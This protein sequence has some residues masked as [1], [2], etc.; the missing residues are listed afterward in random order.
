MHKSLVLLAI[1][2]IGF[3]CNTNQSIEIPDNI[4]LDI[5]KDGHPDFEVSYTLQTEGD[6]IGN[7]QAVRMKLESLNADQI[8]KNLDDFP[9]FLDE[10]ELIQDVVTSPLFWEITDPSPSISFP[11]AIIRTDY[12]EKTWNDKWDVFSLIEKDSYLIGI[13]LLDDN[14]IQLGFIE[15][16]VDGQ[17]GEFII[18]NS[19]LL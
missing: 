18:I 2:L 16:T 4:E 17:T 19:G 8:L 5:D 7:Y 13:K 10:I 14:N 12:D 11:I 1:G 15:F 3:S 6:P 9:L